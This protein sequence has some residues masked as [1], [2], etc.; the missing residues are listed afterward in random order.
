MSFDQNALD[1]LRIE[2]TAEP[3]AASGKPYKWFLLVVLL[4]AVAAAAWAF[5]RNS[6]IEVTTA[7][8]VAASSG[9][10]TSAAVLNASGYVVARRQAT[11]AAKVTGKV[12]EVLIEEGM[13][14]KEGQVI[15]RLDDGTA[16]PVYELAQRQLEGARI[17]LQET[18]V[19]LA[20]LQR[21]LQRTEKLRA[22]KLFI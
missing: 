18:E 3:E 16:R 1:S 21:T 4:I 2:R 7:T 9:T 12:S 11:V 20:E 15:A 8:A 19:R 14:V 10:N 17:N 22:D 5:L 6:A 13:N